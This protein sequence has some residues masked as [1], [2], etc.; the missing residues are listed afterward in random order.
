MQQA[1]HEDVIDVAEEESILQK[2]MRKAARMLRSEA[3]RNRRRELKQVRETKIVNEW[4]RL[5]IRS[6]NGNQ[7]PMPQMF[8]PHK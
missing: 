4:A 1:I 2:D 6:H 3:A 8:L 5:H 7:S